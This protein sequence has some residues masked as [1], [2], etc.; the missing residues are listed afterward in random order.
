M[1]RWDHDIRPVSTVDRIRYIQNC[2]LLYQRG[3]IQALLT[4]PIW[5]EYRYLQNK[6]AAGLG[7]IHCICILVHGIFYNVLLE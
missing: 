6:S 2:L 5:T 7:K 1:Y 4:A 3:G